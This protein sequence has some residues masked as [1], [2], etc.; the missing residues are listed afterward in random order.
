MAR[1]LPNPFNIAGPTFT[2]LLNRISVDWN[3][4]V[5]TLLCRLEA[6]QRHM[7][8]HSHSPMPL[9][10]N[11]L[12][13]PDS[14]TVMEATRQLLNWQPNWR[15][16]A[17][18]TAA[19]ELEAVQVEGHADRGV[20]WH[21]GMMDGKTARLTAQWDGAQLAKREMEI[22]VDAFLKWLKWLHEPENW[23]R[24]VYRRTPKRH[25]PHRRLGATQTPQDKV[26]QSN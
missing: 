19:S 16:E 25:M 9:V 5:G 24:R 20:I 11:E 21:C 10:L 3:E 2:V 13:K 17:T 15:G 8:H 26:Q 7:T 12:D 4:T 14:D 1:Y 6:E 18:R 23:D 22:Y